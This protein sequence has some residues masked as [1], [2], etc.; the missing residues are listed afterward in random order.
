MTQ[1]RKKVSGGTAV[2]RSEECCVRTSPDRRQLTDILRVSFA[3]P[4]FALLALPGISEA[5]TP[6]APAVDAGF[7]HD[8]VSHLPRNARGVMFY[9][10]S[11]N[12]D[13]ADFRVT[14]PDHKGPLALQLRVARNGN[15]RL[16]PV[17]GF[18]PNARYTFAYLPKHE[19]WRFPD[20]MSVTI[21]DAV[22]DTA[23]TYAIDLA[24]RPEIRMIS[25]PGSPACIEPAVAVTQPFSYRLPAS[26]APYRTQLE[27]GTDVRPEPL[28]K[29][30]KHMPELY[31]WPFRLVSY[32]ASIFWPDRGTIDAHYTGADDAIVASCD[33][34]RLRGVLRGTVAF[35]E[36]DD[37]EYRAEPVALDLGRNVLG[38]CRP[39]DALTRTMQIYG[40]KKGLEA[41]CGRTTAFADTPD[42]SS[43]VDATEHW[44]RSL[45][46][47]NDLSPT[48]SLVALAHA[49]H[50][51]QYLPDRN[52]MHRLG[53][54]LEDGID[55]ADRM[56]AASR[57]AGQQ[58]P[59]YRQSI[60]A[61]DYLMQEMPAE[62]RTNAPAM[63][64]P[65]L[66][67]LAAHLAEPVPYRPDT[68]AA[69]I[70][71]AGSLPDSLRTQLMALA[72]GRTPGASHSRAILAALRGPIPARPVKP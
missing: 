11:K 58:E 62:L 13:V 30:S 69:L 53:A 23:G 32:Y 64:T 61:L 54:A 16:E 59:A 2:N 20:R 5:C 4:L 9:L 35:P 10:P 68:V 29:L 25:V 15:I 45:S 55:M 31:G 70:I 40:A 67:R 63:L 34:S 66:P 8:D 7:Y 51:R 42:R 44:E 57:N 39:L 46:L 52:A 17:G 33:Q 41:V 26:L 72:Q 21:D 37:K 48:C 65:L 50:T 60:D 56:W 6:P 28:R 27:Y 43:A 12:P 1:I 47:L 24:P 3:C 22:V 19:R 18:A 36:V 49:T 71:R 14:S 38:Q